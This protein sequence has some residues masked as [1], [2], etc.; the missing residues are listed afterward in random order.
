MVF[1]GIFVMLFV[2]C[3][4]VKSINLEIWDIE[5]VVSVILI[6][7]G[8]LVYDGDG[9]NAYYGVIC[10]SMFGGNFYLNCLYIGGVMFCF[11]VGMIF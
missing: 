10:M 7:F 1:C 9:G 3:V 11:W 4:S 6:V 8:D 2:V 5:E